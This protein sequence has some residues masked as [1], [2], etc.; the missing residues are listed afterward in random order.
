M[1]NMAK[2]NDNTVEDLL[3]ML[4]E[5]ID[6]A[7]AIPFSSD[8][9]VDRNAALDLMDSIRDQFPA[10]IDDAAKI[11]RNRDQFVADAR[12]EATRV[13]DQA[14]TQAQMMIDENEL[15]RKA[16]A[17]AEEAIRNAKA[18]GAEI[19]NKANEEA[20][21]TIDEADSR[22]ES[23]KRAANEYCADALRRTESAVAQAYGEIKDAHEHFRSLAAGSA[24]ASRR[25]V[26]YDVDKDE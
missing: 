17:A 12:R 1:S 10:E 22:A 18:Q 21:R 20:R 23:L 24:A 7:K 25:N 5:M 9:R 11:I 15:V 26:P 6:E 2:V 8:C 16:R 19:I 3:N 13:I 14:K 4:Y